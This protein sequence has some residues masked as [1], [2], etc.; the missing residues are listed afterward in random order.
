MPETPA[1]TSAAPPSQTRDEETPG[2]AL[3]AGLGA[4]R[5][6]FRGPAVVRALTYLVAFGLGA[7]AARV[8]APP[9]PTTIYKYD[10]SFDGSARPDPLSTPPT[11]YDWSWQPPPDFPVP[12]YAAF[13]RGVRIVLDPGHGG[14]AHRGP[15]FKRGP[16]GLREAEV[17]LRVGLY[18]REFLEAVGAE[19]YMTRDSD[20]ALGQTDARDLEQRATYANRA[21]ADLLV[22]LHHNAAPNAAANYSLVFFHDEPDADPASLCA[23]RHIVTGLN[24]ALRLATHVE[25]AIRSDKTVYEDSG[26]RLLRLAQVPAVLIESSFYSHPPEEQRL[27]D[28]LYNRREAY[29]I[30]LGLARWAQAGLPRIAL[31]EPDRGNRSGRVQIQLYDGLSGRGL[32][33]PPM[34][35]IQWNTMRV[36]VNHQPAAY[37]IDYKSDRI[38]LPWSFTELRDSTVL[39]DFE[40]LFGQRVLKPSLKVK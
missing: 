18:L 38:T 22:S 29:G 36:L 2:G 25:C 28:P 11:A 34:S 24:D 1:R 20:T 16:S 39:V 15:G 14:D 17:N 5:V 23:A 3:L 30:F 37:E 21:D 4:A 13:L 32:A 7:V 40:N 31:V 27:A 33:G 19:V 9:G 26:F 10:Y 6:Y 8:L 12:A 35:K